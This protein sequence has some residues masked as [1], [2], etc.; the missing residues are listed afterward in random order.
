MYIRLLEYVHRNARVILPIHSPFATISTVEVIAYIGTFFQVPK[1]VHSSKFIY[2]FCY[3]GE[4]N[5]S[6]CDLLPR[7]V[8]IIV[9]KFD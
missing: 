5:M 8:K 6:S 1:T 2:D 3:C 9:L 4:E 7:A